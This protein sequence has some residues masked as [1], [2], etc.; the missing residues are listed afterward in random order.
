MVLVFSDFT[1]CHSEASLPLRLVFTLGFTVLPF[2]V[3]LILARIFTS[4]DL[5]VSPSLKVN[6][7][8][9]WSLSLTVAVLAMAVQMQQA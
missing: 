3:A 6:L 7:E 8:I 4:S 9:F 2:I 1:F 5:G